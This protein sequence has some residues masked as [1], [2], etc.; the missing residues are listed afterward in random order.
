M[1]DPEGCV[2]CFEEAW[3]NIGL[4]CEYGHFTCWRCLSRMHTDKCVICDPEGAH[5]RPSSSSSGSEG[6]VSPPP[7]SRR[8][9]REARSPEVWVCPVW[10]VFLGVCVLSWITGLAGIAL[11]CLLSPL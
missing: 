9:W 5:R 8:L 7:L 11:V 4:W 6:S 10:C 2:V 3:D 1:E